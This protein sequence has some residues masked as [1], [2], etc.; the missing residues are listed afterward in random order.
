MTNEIDNWDPANPYYWSP[1]EEDVKLLNRAICTDKFNTTEEGAQLDVIR[2]KLKNCLNIGQDKKKCHWWVPTERDVKLIKKAV[3][4][5]TSGLI[6]PQDRAR[7][8]I[9]VMKLMHLPHIAQKEELTEWS[10]K[11]EEMM[12]NICG[13]LI[14]NMSLANS[15]EEVQELKD[16]LNWVQDLKPRHLGDT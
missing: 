12:D 13:I 16:L 9:I 14:N 15:D 4:E 5:N 7:L 8:D 6:T 2:K 3:S 11:D 10:E 1:K